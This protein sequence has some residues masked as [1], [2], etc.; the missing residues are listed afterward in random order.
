[1]L[2]IAFQNVTTKSQFWM[3]FDSKNMSMAFPVIVI[4]VVGMIIGSLFTLFFQSLLSE[5]DEIV[6]KEE[7]STF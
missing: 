3:F 1:L 5:K 4:S 2:I 7:N 6:Q